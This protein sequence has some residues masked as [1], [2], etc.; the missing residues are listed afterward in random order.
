MNFLNWFLEKIKQNKKV[1][2]IFLF[3]FYFVGD[4]FYCS[5]IEKIQTKLSTDIFEI[6]F[7]YLK[8]KNFREKKNK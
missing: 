6:L 3:F 4:N 5:K 1:R 2:E 7:D 8:R